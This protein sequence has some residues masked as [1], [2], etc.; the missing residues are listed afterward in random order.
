MGQFFNVTDLG[1]IAP[2]L[3][4]MLFGMIL[5]IADLLFENKKFTEAAQ[6]CELGRKAEPYE[7]TWLIELAK[8][9]TQ[10]KNDAKL[11]DVLKDLAPTNADDLSVRRKLA[12]LLV[13]S[14]KHAEA[15]RY[16]RQA[17]EI[18]VTDR[19]AQ[20]LLRES[21]QAQGKEEELRQLKKLLGE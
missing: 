12:E 18:E 5:L 21:L 3:E 20:R 15:E 14:G 7:N 10:G 6:V 1:A 11:I 13:K 2:E 16:A 19:E 8:A 4:L 17:L 9:Y